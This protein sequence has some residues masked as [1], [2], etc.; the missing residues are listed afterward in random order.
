MSKKTTVTSEYEE[1]AWDE[2][3]ITS[4]QV[5]MR[6]RQI[7]EKAY[8]PYSGFHVGAAVRLESGEIVQASN[9]EN[10]SFPV[11]VCAERL[12]LGY[13]GANFP[14]LAIE[15]IAIVAKRK[16]DKEWAGVS[17]CGLCRQAINEAEMRFQNEITLLIQKPDGNVLRFKGIQT[18]LPFKFDDLNA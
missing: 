7:S 17:P 11:G 6:A 15:E 3:P 14:D 2:L 9:Q 16:G 13:A 10:I 18:L 5:L 12:V 8:A 1:L 4:Q